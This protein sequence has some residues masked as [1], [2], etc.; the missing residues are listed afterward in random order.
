MANNNLAVIEEFIET[1]LENRQHGGDPGTDRKLKAYISNAKRAQA[2]V[3]ALI[4]EVKPLKSVFDGTNW[5]LLKQQKG[6][7]VAVISQAENDLRHK[8]DSDLDQEDIDRLSGILN[9]IDALQ[10]AAEIEGYPVVFHE[11]EEEGEKTV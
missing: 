11:E 7:L 8:V 5:E 9:W 6:T 1:E 4:T 10:D 2:A 3:N